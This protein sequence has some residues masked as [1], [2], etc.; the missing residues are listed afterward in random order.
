[1]VLS[2]RCIQIMFNLAKLSSVTKGEDHYVSVD[3]RVDTSVDR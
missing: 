1:M 2:G 3:T